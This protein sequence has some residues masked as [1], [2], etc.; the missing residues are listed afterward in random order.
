MMGT[1]DVFV[2]KGNKLAAS[3]VGV[4]INLAGLCR[5]SGTSKESKS[6]CEPQLYGH[7]GVPL[8]EG[9]SG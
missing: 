5:E 9:G 4:D 3:H 8:E 1:N 6:N 7:G 2:A